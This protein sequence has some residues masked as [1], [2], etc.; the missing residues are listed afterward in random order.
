MLSDMIFKSIFYF[1]I[2]IPTIGMYFLKKTLKYQS[3]NFL[4]KKFE[5]PKKIMMHTHF[6]QE[7]PQLIGPRVTLSPIMHNFEYI[8][9]SL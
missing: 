7:V 3:F 2:F 8:Q 9:I 5:P 4:P 6:L 1:P